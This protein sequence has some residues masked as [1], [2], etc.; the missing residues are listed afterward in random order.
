MKKFL[1][2]LLFLGGMALAGW[3]FHGYAT[4]GEEIESKK[5]AGTTG[6]VRTVKLSFE[7]SPVRLILSVDYKI[8]LRDQINKAYRYE[9]ELVA[10]SGMAVLQAS[11]TH[12]VKKED[13]GNGYDN[14]D[15][16]HI[17]GTFEVQEEGVYTLNWLVKKQQADIRNIGFSLRSN[18]RSL[19]WPTMALAGGIF[20]LGFVVVIA[21]RK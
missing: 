4:S 3:E 9:A 17:L 7:M 8:F 11:N 16:N 15:L 2:L 21:T 12:S 18:V 10:P 14:G 19:H 20:L 13:R 6:Q 5:L 1:S